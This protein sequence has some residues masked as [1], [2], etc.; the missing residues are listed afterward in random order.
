M[1]A[2]AQDFAGSPD[3]TARQDFGLCGNRSNC[4][5]LEARGGSDVLLVI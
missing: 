5:G 3:V 4:G 1:S 2:I